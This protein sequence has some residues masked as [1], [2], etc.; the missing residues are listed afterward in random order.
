MTVKWNGVPDKPECSG[1]HWVE[2]ATGLRP[3]LWRGDDWPEKA[4]CREWQDGTIICSP[5]DMCGDRYFGPVTMPEVVASRFRATYI[6]QP[7]LRGSNLWTS[8][9]RL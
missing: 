1:W 5:S 2:D 9:L 3:L 7:T 4:D 6:A 8:L